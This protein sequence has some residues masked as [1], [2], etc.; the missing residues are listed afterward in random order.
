MGV[1]AL[2]RRVRNKF[3]RMRAWIKGTKRCDRGSGS[4]IKIQTRKGRG[5][6]EKA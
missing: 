2:D 3:S 6:V 5:A 4:E 1:G